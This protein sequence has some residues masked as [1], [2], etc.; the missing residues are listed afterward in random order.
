MRIDQEL[1]QISLIIM[2]S[3]YYIFDTEAEAQAVNAEIYDLH[4]DQPVSERTTLYAYPIFTNDTQFALEYSGELDDQGL[5]TGTPLTEQQV[6][7]LGFNLD[8]PL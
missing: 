5:L 6:I 3:D 4:V 7:D 1:K 2:A 8:Q